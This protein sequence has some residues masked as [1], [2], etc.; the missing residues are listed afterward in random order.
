MS[1]L[2]LFIVDL[3]F[4]DKMTHVLCVTSTLAL[5]ADPLITSAIGVSPSV[6]LAAEALR[7]ISNVLVVR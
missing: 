5:L 6:A 7:A 4:F 2:K 1:L 3:L